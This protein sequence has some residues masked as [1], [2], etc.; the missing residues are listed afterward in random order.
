MSTAVQP[1]TTPPVRVSSSHT[2]LVIA[3]VYG[4]LVVL[5]GLVIAGYVVPLLWQQYAAP[6]TSQL[7]GFLSLS[8]RLIVQLVAAGVVIYAGTRLAGNN[9]PRGIRGGIFLVI[10]MIIGIFFIVRAFNFQLA[11]LAYGTPVS[12][13]V[14]GVLAFGAFKV[15]MSPWAEAKMHAIEEQGWFHTNSFKATQGL[16]VRRYTLIGVLIVGLTGAWSLYHHMALG[17]GDLML[18]MPFY[19]KAIAVLSSKE[20]TVPLVIA[21]L[22]GWFAWRLVNVPTFA[23]FLIATEAEMNKVSWS[24]RKRLFQ[25]TVVVLVTVVILTSFLLIVDLFWGWLLSQP[26]IGVLP[27]K[28]AE[29]QKQGPGESLNW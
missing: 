5:G 26:F 28:A 21:L 22:T 3:S 25:D 11:D 20:V 12:L 6:A 17:T 16:K 15:L 29:V 19:D 9:P 4:A 1:T 18:S 24:T 27:A 10:S 13:V 23:D 8:L 2:S 14:L 7:P